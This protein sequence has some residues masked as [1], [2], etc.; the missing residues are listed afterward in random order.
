MTDFKTVYIALGAN[1]DDREYYLRK[2]IGLIASSENISVSGVSNIYE[3][4]PVG[5]TQQDSFLNMVIR[6]KT[7]ISPLE[8]LGVLQNIEN[9]LKRARTIRWGPRNIDIDILMFESVQM[10]EEELILP[11]PRMKERAFVLVPLMDVLEESQRECND[12]E[13]TSKSC[14]DFEGVKLFKA[15]NYSIGSIC[16]EL[17]EVGSTNDYLKDK[18]FMGAAHGT[19]AIAK[20]QSRGKGRMGRSWSSMNEDGIWLSI[21]LRPEDSLKNIANLTQVFAVSI[22]DTLRD[23]CNL[24]SKIKWPNDIILENKKVCGIL[25]ESNFLGSCCDFVIVG[26]GINVNQEN[27]QEDLNNIAIS[28][29]MHS[30][31]VY[32]KQEIINK[33]IKNSDKLYID[34]ANE[35]KDVMGNY[36]KYSTTIGREVKVTINDVERICYAMDINDNGELVIKNNEG[37]IEAISAGEVLVRGIYNYN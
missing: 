24:E 7:N 31:I 18:A 21:L 9:T 19:M 26:I 35:K 14:G 1:I 12:F 4:E 37:S 22:V 28:L 36:R 16:I 23:V 20:K 8:L 25:S 30:G 29:K 5:Y 27:F 13:N 11:H 15:W 17:D 32:D 10:Q 34:F 2:A 6:V 3:T 33:L